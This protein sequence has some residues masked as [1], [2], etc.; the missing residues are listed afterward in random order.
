MEALAA[1]LD[2]VKERLSAEDHQLLVDTVGTLAVLTRELETKGTSIQ[3]L[4]KMIFGSGSEKLRQL[5]DDDPPEPGIP[6]DSSDEGAD[7]PDQGSDPSAENAPATEPAG[8]TKKRPGHGRNGA[9]SYQS[10]EK[11]PVPHGSLHPGGG[12][13][14]CD[15]GRLY[16]LNESGVL[17]RV[18]GMA[19]L[20]AKVYALERLRC[21]GCGKVFTAAPPSEVGHKK[22]DET[23]AA[24]IILLKYGAGVPFTR[25]EKLQGSIGIPLPKGTQWAVVAEA[26]D[27]LDLAWD[28]LVT[29]AA[30]AVVLHNDDTVMKI[31]DIDAPMPWEKG[32]PGDTPKEAMD[33]DRT[34]MFTSGI[35]A[36]TA[37]GG[38][39]IALFYTGRKHAGENIAGVLAER[40]ADLA[41][42]IQMCDAL[43][44]NTVPDMNTVRAYCTTH[45]RRKFV[46]VAE[47]FPEQVRH[48]LEQLRLVYR[49]DTV[50]R[51]EGMSADKRLQFHQENS[52][53][54]MAELRLWLARQLDE[55][56]IEPNSSLGDAITYM[57]KHWEPLTLFLRVAGA[58]MDNNICERALKRAIL[59]RKNALFYKTRNGA[60][61][62]DIFMSLIH[63][64][65]LNGANVFHYLVALLRH[66]QELSDSPEEWMPW[67]YH[68]T[69]AK[70][71][72]R[73]LPPV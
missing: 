62:G 65:E 67:N 40:R 9:T 33:P 13:P 50:T 68:L 29:Q 59:H 45:A 56:L 57:V 60:R 5:F 1:V 70:I 54:V 8:S 21:A 61:V 44:R 4:R 55:H 14:G 15:G 38:P 24:M 37:E 72:L 6:A 3:R 48:V 34:G 53:P 64:A 51:D 58:P 73:A 52:A 26:A 2:R 23:A 18:T 41:A 49:N 43:S 42:P 22:Y 12:C 71:A 25:L 47:S 7:E 36:E 27:T 19:P 20:T 63:T 39:K 46:E 35:I 17:V 30:Q 10:A 11:V 28:E 16:V 69:L 66:P 31:L 32:I